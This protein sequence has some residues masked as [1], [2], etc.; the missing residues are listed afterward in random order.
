MSLLKKIRGVERIF[1]SLEKDVNKFKEVT[2]LTCPAGCIHCCL[3]EDI[4]ATVLE[5]LPLSYELYRLKEGDRYLDLLESGVH[6]NCIL[7]N[8]LSTDTF[9]GGCSLYDKRGLICRLFGFSSVTDKN[10]MPRLITCKTLKEKLPYLN[11]DTAK[12]ASENRI[13]AISK[14]QSRLYS[15]D[16]VLAGKRYPVNTAIKK[17]L[18]MVLF[19]YSFK[20]R[21]AG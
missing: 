1:D 2:G 19:Y 7:F 9:N 12:L 14:Y 6:K 17:A 18:E 10:G 16:F 15:I 11:K 13:P 3:K 8:P 21:K 4:E 20:G 5:F